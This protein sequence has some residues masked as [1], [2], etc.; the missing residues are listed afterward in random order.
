MNTEATYAI[1]WSLSFTYSSDL[2][3]TREI[4]T[5]PERKCEFIISDDDQA[6]SRQRKF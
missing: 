6:V 3:Y 1:Q 4:Y 5:K 2:T